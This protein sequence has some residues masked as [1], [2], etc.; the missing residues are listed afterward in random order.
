MLKLEPQIFV[1]IIGV[2]MKQLGVIS[3]FLFQY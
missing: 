2:A 3:K 1:L